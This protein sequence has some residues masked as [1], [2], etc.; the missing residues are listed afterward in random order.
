MTDSSIIIY[1]K[2]SDIIVLCFF[3]FNSN[4]TFCNTLVMTSDCVFT[5]ALILTAFNIDCI[6]W[7]HQQDFRAV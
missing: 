2:F 5:G 4:E 1:I 7:M 3:L 6:P